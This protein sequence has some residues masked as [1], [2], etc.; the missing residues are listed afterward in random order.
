MPLAPI[1]GSS[2]AASR[3]RR[4]ALSLWFPILLIGF[5]LPLP[6]FFGKNMTDPLKQAVSDVAENILCYAHYP[7]GRT[8]FA[9]TKW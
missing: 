4:S 3:G 9:R 1:L 2:V 5:L 8:G 7:A 6:A